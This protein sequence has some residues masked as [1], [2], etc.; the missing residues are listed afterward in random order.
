MMKYALGIILCYG[1]TVFLSV[2]GLQAQEYK[3]PPPPPPPP[4]KWV[5][6]TIK[7]ES[8]QM[9][10]RP[11]FPGCEDE[12]NPHRRWECG[13]EKLKVLLSKRIVYPVGAIEAGVSGTV[14][15]TYVISKNGELNTVKIVEDI[16]GDCG[17]IVKAALETLS[18]EGIRFQ[19][20]GTLGG[21]LRPMAVQFELSV[22]FV[23]GMV[24]IGN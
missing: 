13:D 2:P 16:G 19:P 18:R 8:M 11:R 6:D 21:R 24:K 4:E 17:K 14:R 3:P 22:Q 12:P 20:M 10:L 1:V 23:D 5:E 15:L 9:R 7:G